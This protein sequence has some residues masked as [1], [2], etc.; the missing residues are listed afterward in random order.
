MARPLALGVSLFLIHSVTHLPAAMASPI[1]SEPSCET[2]V[3]LDAPGGTLEKSPIVDQDGLGIC[4]AE[5]AAQVFDALLTQQRIKHPRSSALDAALLTKGE[6]FALPKAENNGGID[7]GDSCLAFDALMASGALAHDEVMKR[8]DREYP[9]RSIQRLFEIFDKHEETLK[10][11][12]ESLKRAAGGSSSNEIRNRAI[13]TLQNHALDLLDELSSCKK[14]EPMILNV[15]SFNQLVDILRTQDF[16][17]LVVAVSG[18]G[19][20]SNQRLK[21]PFGARCSSIPAGRLSDT[22]RSKLIAKE[23][24]ARL[25]DGKTGLPIVVNYCSSLLEKGRDW[26]S[27]SEC[28]NHSSLVVGYRKKDG[29]CQALIRNS[30]GT[31]CAMYSKEWECKRGQI[32]VDLDALAADSGTI[33]VVEKVR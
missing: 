2:E 11:Q 4:F 33:Q 8:L 13:T 14:R 18:V 10:A 23:I 7:G 30:W 12:F 16:P 26:R 27:S 6:A 9:R 32:W 3:R 17:A 15:P 29:K 1:A 31:D 22:S 20:K 24:L 28:R 19:G 21:L 25:G 5:T